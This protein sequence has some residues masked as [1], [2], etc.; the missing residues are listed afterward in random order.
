MCLCIG[1]T[2]VT[3]IWERH[4]VRVVETKTI[5]STVRSEWCVVTAMVGL[6]TT[7]VGSFDVLGAFGEDLL[8]DGALLSD[9]GLDHI[10]V[11]VR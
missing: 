7:V 10:F 5:M 6:P 9:R 4:D 8:F 11:M 2:F 3:R 1:F